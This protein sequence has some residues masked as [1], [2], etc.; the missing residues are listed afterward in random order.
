MATNATRQR[1]IEIDRAQQMWNA[2]RCQSLVQLDRDELV[3]FFGDDFFELLMF[4]KIW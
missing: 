4:S 1:D 3:V 2:Y